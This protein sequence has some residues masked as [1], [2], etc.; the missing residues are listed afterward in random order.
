MFPLPDRAT[1]FGILR[2]FE[3][4]TAKWYGTGA[5]R[6]E[7]AVSVLPLIQLLGLF[8]GE[9]LLV[10]L[11]KTGRQKEPKLAGLPEF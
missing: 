10:C 4:A 1:H 11:K 8:F 2:V 6:P 5:A 9:P 3:F 7:G